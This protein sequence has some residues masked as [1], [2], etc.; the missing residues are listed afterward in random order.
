MKKISV[1]FVMF[2]LVFL[3]GCGDSPKSVAQKWQKAIIDSDLKAANALSTEK[4][5]SCNALIIAMVSNK[6]HEFYTKFREK[7]FNKEEI[8]GDK[9]VVTTDGSGKL[10]LV[11][12]NGKWLVDVGK[13]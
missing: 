1:V 10:D 9:A 4:S 8:T 6:D 11:K 3:V 12:Q 2:L 5:Q 7:V 13:E